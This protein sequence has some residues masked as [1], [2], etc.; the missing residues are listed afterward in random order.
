MAR[1][2]GF[3]PARCAYVAYRDENA[4]PGRPPRTRLKRV[5]SRLDAAPEIVNTL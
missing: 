2:G 1:R 4:S 5:I 3:R